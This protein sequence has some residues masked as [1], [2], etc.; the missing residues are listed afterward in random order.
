MGSLPLASKALGGHWNPVSRSQQ[1]QS[2]KEWT[3]QASTYRY[4]ILDYLQAYTIKRYLKWHSK[5]QLRSSA[6]CHIALCLHADRRTVAGTGHSIEDKICTIRSCKYFPPAWNFPSEMRSL[7]SPQNGSVH[8]LNART[9]GHL[10][11]SNVT[12]A[13]A[14]LSPDVTPVAVSPFGHAWNSVAMDSYHVV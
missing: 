4:G 11:T 3:Q 12:W 7:G 9:I 14:T 1:N 2:W 13:R 10:S 6:S 5:Q 8:T